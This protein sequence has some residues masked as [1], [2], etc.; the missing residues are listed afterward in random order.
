MR[1]RWKWSAEDLL[2]LE[3]LLARGWTDRKIGE[4]LGCS[5]VAVV[6][7]RKRNRI[8][9][10]RRFLLSAR[11]VARRLGLSCSKPVAQWIKAGYL[12][13][14]RCQGAGPHRMWY[15]T[16]DALL[17]FLE[18][19]R[20]WHLWSPGV[21]EPSLGSWVAE[22]RNGVRFLTTREAG[23]VLCVSHYS[24]RR[25]IQAGLLP[26]V[27]CGNWLVGESDLHGF[28]LP[29]ERSKKGKRPRRFSP[30]EDVQLVSLRMEGKR[31]A[32]IAGCLRR[33]LGSCAGRLALLEAR[34]A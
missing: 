18:D 34:S 19:I 21:L 23:R 7:A 9:P 8:P 15:V 6:V 27:R 22:M 13:A 16:E 33:P 25:Y 4:D 26:A 14:R 31:L 24:V 29:C 17:R 10:R 3:E 11:A 1:S 28:V 5:A 12:K 30:Q 2:R 20:Y 32:E